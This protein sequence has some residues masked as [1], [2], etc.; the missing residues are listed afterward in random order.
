MCELTIEME[1][2]IDGNSFDKDYKN[3][4]KQYLATGDM[5]FFDSPLVQDILSLHMA[6]NNIN[7]N[8]GFN[9]AMEYYRKYL[10]VPE[11]EFDALCL[12]QSG[13]LYKRL[14][15]KLDNAYILY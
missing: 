10:A 13:N 15:N 1:L 14:K 4:T 2:D 6:Y 5:S 3:A 12:Y 11:N 7:N 8:A 9:Q